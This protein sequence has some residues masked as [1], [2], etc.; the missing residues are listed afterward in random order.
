MAANRNPRPPAKTPEAR[1]QQLTAMAID[2]VE[3]Q[4]R[5]GTVSAQVLAHYVK[6]SSPREKAELEKLE[7]ENQTLRAKI[8]Q[9]ENASQS[10]SMY[11]EALNAMRRYS[12]QEVP[13][14][15]YDDA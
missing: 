12:G 14:D 6:K 4:I 2:L 9:M 1:E 3:K 10:E 13:N 7:L 8:S 11:L 5:E 15:E